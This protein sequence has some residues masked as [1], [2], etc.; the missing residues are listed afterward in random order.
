M[1][2]RKVRAAVFGSAERPSSGGPGECYQNNLVQIVPFFDPALCLAAQL[3]ARQRK[4]IASSLL[5]SSV[6]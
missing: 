4:F 6:S 5:L 2:L 1:G 3:P